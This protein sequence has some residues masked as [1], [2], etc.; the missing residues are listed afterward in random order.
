[1]KLGVDCSREVDISLQN[2]RGRFIDLK[3]SV[4]A[5]LLVSFAGFV[6]AKMT[7]M[8]FKIPRIG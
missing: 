1:M 2:S 6:Y 7:A 4:C 5:R 3:L 8:S